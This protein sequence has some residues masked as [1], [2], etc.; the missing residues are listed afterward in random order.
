MSRQGLDAWGDL[1]K[2]MIAD[3]DHIIIFAG[4]APED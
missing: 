3:K 2:K 1:M 4:G